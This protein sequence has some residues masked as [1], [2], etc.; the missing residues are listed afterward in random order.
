VAIPYLIELIKGRFPDVLVK[1]SYNAKVRSVEQAVSFERLGADLIC[2]DQS[3]HRNFP[4]L[5]AIA[6]GVKA[7]IQV[8]CTVDCLAGCP[9]MAAMYHMNN[10][11]TLSSERKQFDRNTRH[12]VSYCISWCHL[13]KVVAPERIIKGGFIRPEDL[14]HYEAVGINQ[15]KLDTR[16]LTTDHIM[17][18]VQAYTSRRYDGDLKRLLSVFPIGF[19]TRVSEL[20]ERPSA[21]E[22][23]PAFAEFFSLKQ[24]FDFDGMLTIDN[25]ALDG[26]L[27]R[28]VGHP[29]P[30]SCQGCNYCAAF[31]NKACRWSEDRRNELLRIFES[32]RGALLEG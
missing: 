19:K 18:R 28:F 30:P 11:C 23:D 9:N 7:P 17:E 8:I 1:A 2:V 24:R 21:P 26:F 32:Y 22:D 12:A 13:M 5:K 10:T 29:C 14:H 3:I 20:E 6:A 16:V 27:E 4:L 31:A 25:R 15:F